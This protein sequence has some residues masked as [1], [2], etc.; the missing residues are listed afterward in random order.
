MAN[1]ST[2]FPNIN[3]QD[4]E[5]SLAQVAGRVLEGNAPI[6]DRESAYAIHREYDRI[7]DI[8]MEDQETWQR[9][10]GIYWYRK[11][12]SCR[13]VW[14]RLEDSLKR[15]YLDR[16]R[17]EYMRAMQTGQLDRT[18][19]TAADWKKIRS[20]IN[21]SEGAASM[22]R[23]IPLISRLAPFVPECI[24]SATI[25]CINH[26]LGFGKKLIASVKKSR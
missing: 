1:M 3:G 2:L 22:L 8:L 19:F 26:I 20:M 12:H 21:R 25:R 17:R 14:N 18:L 24:R 23:A 13:E 16:A 10:Q 6:A 4:L 7:R 9:F 11:F 5:E 15:E